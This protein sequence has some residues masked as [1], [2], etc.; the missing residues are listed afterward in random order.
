MRAVDSV[1][2]ERICATSAMLGV[3]IE[4]GAG[5]GAETTAAALATGAVSTTETIFGA[6]AAVTRGAA[7]MTGAV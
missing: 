1:A 2:S 6:S 5:A 4:A 3:T 7:V